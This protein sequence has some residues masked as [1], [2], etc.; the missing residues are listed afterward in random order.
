[1]YKE[2]KIKAIV[3]SLLFSLFCS[4][5]CYF[6]LDFASKNPDKIDALEIT[7]IIM[8]LLIIFS[9]CYQFG[10]YIISDSQKKGCKRK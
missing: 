1:M 8:P 7:L 10:K 2:S 3:S 9:M 5:L 6:C 4:F